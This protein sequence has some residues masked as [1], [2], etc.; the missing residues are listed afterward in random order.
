LNGASRGILIKGGD[1]IE[2]AASIDFAVLDKTGTITEGKPKLSEALGVGMP[3]E[4]ALRLA[5]SLERRSEHSIG[6]AI[7][8]AA[9]GLEPSE[10]TDFS[11]VP[12]KGVKGMIQGKPALIGSRGFLESETGKES[13]D[14][15]LDS[16]HLLRL[17]ENE[18]TGST[19]IFL[20]FDGFVRGVFAV[21]D[22]IRKESA[23]AVAMIKKAGMDV[24]MVTGD[25]RNTGEAVARQVGI[26]SVMAQVSPM[27]KAEVVQRIENQ[28]KHVLMAGDGINDA[29]RWWRPQ[30]A[31]PWS[32]YGHRPRK[33]DIVIMHPDLRLVADAV[34]LTRRPSG[35]SIR[36]SSG[37]S[38]QSRLSPWRCSASCTRSWPPAPWRS[39]RSLWS[40][41]HCVRGCGKWGAHCC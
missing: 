12:G 29:P 3:G 15:V 39:V 14:A 37:R 31:L 20:C 9:R 41:I 22:N 19:I 1:V 10:V 6:R 32:G 4:E 30:S 18:R 38:L 13:I 34:A 17:R 23:E 8:E 2:K 25:N 35:S 36:T 5:M 26:D 21:S 27:E 16:N 33:R 11:A 28:G 24:A 40:E 7:V